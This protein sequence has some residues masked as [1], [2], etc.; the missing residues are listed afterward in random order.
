MTNC[1]GGSSGGRSVR[2]ACPLAKDG[3]PERCGS[4]SIVAAGSAQTVSLGVELSLGERQRTVLLYP[5]EA[6]LVKLPAGKP[7]QGSGNPVFPGF[8]TRQTWCPPRI[9]VDTSMNVTKP[10]PYPS[11]LH[12]KFQ[13]NLDRSPQR[14]DCLGRRHDPDQWRHAVALQD[15]RR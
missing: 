12:G 3:S 15:V 8:L 10:L 2:L 1:G 5:A 7:E 11:A 9:K 4:S 6:R 13:A 14:S